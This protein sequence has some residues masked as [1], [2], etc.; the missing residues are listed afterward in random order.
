MHK[1]DLGFDAE[2]N[3][4]AT[5]HGKS[6]CD[7]IGGNVKR[8]TAIES[9]KRINK[10]QILNAKDMFHF[11]KQHFSRFHFSTS[12]KTKSFTEQICTCQE[13]PGI[14]SCHRFKPISSFILDFMR[15]SDE[16]DCP[17]KW[18]LEIGAKEL[19]LE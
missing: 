13:D 11:C 19:Q 3:F 14:R 8:C 10:A 16:D 5:A 18:K 2:W 6:P 12:P 17:I 15:T 7:G 1:R 4:F 9:L